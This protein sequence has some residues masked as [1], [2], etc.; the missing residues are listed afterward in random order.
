MAEQQKV[1]IKLDG[2]D[3]DDFEDIADDIKQYIKDRSD[4]G[5]GVRRRGSGF[6][7]YDFPDYSPKYEKFKGSSKVDLYLD[8]D[9]LDAIETLKTTKS[10]ITIGFESGTVEKPGGF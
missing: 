9:M 2:Y 4:T 1:E 5:V 3:P 7:N 8:G 10:S 6:T